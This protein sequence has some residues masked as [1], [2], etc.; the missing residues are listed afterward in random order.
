LNGKALKRCECRSFVV[1]ALEDFLNI[2]DRDD[3]RT[4]AQRRQKPPRRP[5]VASGDFL[6]ERDEKGRVQ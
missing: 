6:L 2:D 3:K 1:R 5:L 4:P